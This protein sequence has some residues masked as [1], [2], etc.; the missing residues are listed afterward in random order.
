MSCGARHQHIANVANGP[1]GIQT[2]GADIDAVL[3]TVTTE[4]AEGVIQPG[5]AF[6]SGRIARVGEKAVGL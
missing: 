3:Y 5:Q 4:Y 2:L 1:G 6:L